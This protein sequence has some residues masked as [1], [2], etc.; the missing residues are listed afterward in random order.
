MIDVAPVIGREN[1]NRIFLAASL[2]DLPETDTAIW[3][4]LVPF[5]AVCAYKRIFAT[6]G[7]DVTQTGITQPKVQNDFE[8]ISDKRRGEILGLI[9]SRINFYQGELELNLKIR[10]YLETPDSCS[11]SGPRKSFGFAIAKKKLLREL[12][13]RFLLR[14]W[15]LFPFPLLLAVASQ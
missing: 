10:N 3:P 7:V 5:W 11:H 15:R 2:S 4:F 12:G 14:L 8:H 9:R 1:Y 13:R 6:L